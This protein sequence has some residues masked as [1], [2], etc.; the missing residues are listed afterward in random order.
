MRFRLFRSRAFWF[1][2]PGLVFLLWGWWVSMGH[3]SVAMFKGTGVGGSWGIGQMG[4]EVYVVWDAALGPDWGSFG[5]GHEEIQWERAR[6][7][8]GTWVAVC[9]KSPSRRIDFIPY[10]WP[11]L[12]YVAGWAGLVGWRS[13]KYRAMPELR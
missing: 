9:E 5:A 2:V 6:Q 1:G 12:A 4:G 7:L 3:Q 10:H 8:K 11:V 13:R